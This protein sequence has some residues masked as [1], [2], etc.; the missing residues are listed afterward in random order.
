M[1][2]PALPPFRACAGP[3]VTL[4]FPENPKVTPEASGRVIHMSASH[5]P[6]AW[7]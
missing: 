4:A 1:L 7:Q 6:A 5:L 3:V 2:I